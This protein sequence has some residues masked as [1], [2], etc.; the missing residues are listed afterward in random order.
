MRIESDALQRSFS[1]VYIYN[2]SVLKQDVGQITNYFLYK[3]H[4]PNS[5]TKNLGQ[6]EGEAEGEMDGEVEVLNHI[7]VHNVVVGCN[8]KIH[9]AILLRYTHVEKYLSLKLIYNKVSI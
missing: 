3:Y 6:L 5:V 8:L 9:V 7:H 4:K 1:T 2:G